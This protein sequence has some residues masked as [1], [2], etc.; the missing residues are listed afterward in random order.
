MRVKG[1]LGLL[2]MVA[3][4]ALAAGCGSSDSSGTSAAGTGSET[5]SSDGGSSGEDGTTKNASGQDGGSGKPLTKAEFIKEGDAICGQI[6]VEYEKLR[7]EL[8]KGPEKNKASA[9]K[10]NEVA[11]IPPIFTAV[12]SFEKLTPPKGEEAEAEAII[13]ALEAAGKGLEEE[14]SAPLVGP[15]SPYAEF[16]KLTTS[17][18]FKFCPEL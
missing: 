11:A 7:Q 13:A 14:P 12:E 9:S 4:I 16:V 18:G 6:P 3:L 5:T 1:I 17:Y 10:V 8:L 15:K 2:S